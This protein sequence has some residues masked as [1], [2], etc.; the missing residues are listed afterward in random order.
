MDALKERED[1]REDVA[2]CRRRKLVAM[3]RSSSFLQAFFFILEPKWGICAGKIL[4]KPSV[5]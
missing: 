1:A 4:G 5:I 2:S 3:R